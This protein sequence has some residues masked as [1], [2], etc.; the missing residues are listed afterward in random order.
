MSDFGGNHVRDLHRVS[1]EA[2][3]PKS[4]AGG[5][6]GGGVVGGGGGC[7]LSPTDGWS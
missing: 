4:M 5:R 7:P 1:T 2:S 6:G 3:G